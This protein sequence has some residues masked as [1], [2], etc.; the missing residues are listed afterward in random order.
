[1]RG[2]QTDSVDLKAVGITVTT[3][4]GVLYLILDVLKTVDGD[5]IRRVETTQVYSPC[6]TCQWPE[7]LGAAVVVSVVVVAIGLIMRYFGG[8]DSE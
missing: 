2:H 3:A 4:G 5:A 8:A 6:Y 1:M 7:L